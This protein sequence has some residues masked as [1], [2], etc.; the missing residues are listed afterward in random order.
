LGHFARAANAVLQ[1]LEALIMCFE[2]K[3]RLHY[4]TGHRQVM[5]T[6]VSVW[7]TE[8]QWQ[9]HWITGV[10][11]CEFAYLTKIR[12]GLPIMQSV[13]VHTRAPSWRPNLEAPPHRQTRV[14]L[15]YI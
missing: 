11:L 9:P 6:T 15:T 12:A 8:S 4:P 3:H 2:K 10:C 5:P 7:S 1:F 14:S 13:H